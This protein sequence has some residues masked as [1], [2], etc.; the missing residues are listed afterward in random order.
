M[1]VFVS[2]SVC[3]CVCFCPCLSLCVSLP[4]CVCVCVCVCLCVLLF[5]ARSIQMCVLTAQHR[6]EKRPTGRQTPGERDKGN[7]AESNCVQGSRNQIYCERFCVGS[8]D[9]ISTHLWQR[10]IA[11]P[12]QFNNGL[13]LWCRRS[14]N[15]LCFLTCRGVWAFRTT[16]IWILCHVEKFP[17]F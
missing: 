8:T 13:H 11:P 2:V 9:L 15:N 3:V 14:H 5:S 7:E 4:L 16:G 17:T 10:L 1:C 6:E 12:R